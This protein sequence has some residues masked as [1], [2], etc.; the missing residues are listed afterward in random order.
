MSVHLRPLTEPVSPV[1][2]VAA[3]PDAAAG[4]PTPK[5][6]LAFLQRVIAEAGELRGRLDA[7][8]AELE[9]TA[10]RLTAAFGEGPKLTA[11]AAA[12][13]EVPPAA[14]PAS[15]ELHPAS[16]AM[17]VAIEMAVLGHSRDEVRARL[18]DAFSIAQPDEIVD[19]VFGPAT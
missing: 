13:A 8:Y 16:P 5:Q 15:A 14:P 3:V 4:A 6:M 11:V 10:A 1:T 7:L 19:A 9:A 2:P 17:S 18:T 12:G